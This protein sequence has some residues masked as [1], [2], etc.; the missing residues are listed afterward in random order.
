MKHWVNF[1]IFWKKTMNVETFSLKGS[2]IGHKN[3]KELI[4]PSKIALP[5]DCEER[6]NSKKQYQGKCVKCWG[7]GMVNL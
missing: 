6:E 2:Y 3:L 5:D 1:N 7:G 4:A